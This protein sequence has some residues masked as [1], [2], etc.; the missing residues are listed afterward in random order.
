MGVEGVFGC[1][2]YKVVLYFFLSRVFTRPIAIRF[3]GVGVEVTEDC[4]M[5]DLGKFL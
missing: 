1:D 4:Q 3:E 2:G 5:L